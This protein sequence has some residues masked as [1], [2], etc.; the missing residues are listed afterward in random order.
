[1][2]DRYRNRYRVA[3]ASERVRRQIAIEAAR[4][5]YGTLIPAGRE[6]PPGWLDQATTND[7][8]VAKRKAAAVLGQRIRPGDLPSDAEVR[9]QVIALQRESDGEPEAG[10]AMPEPGP[11]DVPLALAD[12]LDRLAIYRMRLL[13]LE[14]VKQNPKYHPEGDALYHSLQVFHLARDARPYDEEF[15]LAALLH[16]VGKAIDPQD[17][18]T[19]GVDALRGAVTERT[20]WLIEHHMDL[21]AARDKPLP[22]RVKRELE[23]SEYFDD[24]KLLRELDDAGRVTGQ[25]VESV[26][27]VLAYL[28]GLEDESYLEP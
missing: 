2:H 15:L 14:S 22:A 23:S 8:Y 7:L 11:D 18:V 25:P 17:H 9:E 28:K 20:L 27:E 21:L 5:L 24:L 26:D 19:A 10:A 13:P 6:P 16:D 4:R 1:M 12:H 3:A